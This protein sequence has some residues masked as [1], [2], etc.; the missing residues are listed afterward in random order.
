MGSIALLRQ[1]YLDAQWNQRNPRREQNLSLQA[2][3][4][5]KG[6]PAIFQASDS[7]VRR[8]DVFIALSSSA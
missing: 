8:P 3:I 2:L 4:Q 6:L 5:Q 7:R 1:T